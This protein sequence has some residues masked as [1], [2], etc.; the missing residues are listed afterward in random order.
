MIKHAESSRNLAIISYCFFIL[1]WYLPV[2]LFFRIGLIF[3]PLLQ[4]NFLPHLFH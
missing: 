3:V 1:F 2:A 4:Q